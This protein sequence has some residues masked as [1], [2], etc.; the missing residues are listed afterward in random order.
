MPSEVLEL[1]R[2]EPVRNA[3][4]AEETPDPRAFGLPRAD[5]NID[6]IVLRKD[7]PV[8][9]GD[10]RQFDDRPTVIALS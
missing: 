4:I 5:P 8:A 10:I 2:V 7:P 3:H 6:V 9:P 1:A